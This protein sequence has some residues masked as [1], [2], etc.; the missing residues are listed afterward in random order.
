[1]EFT[2]VGLRDGSFVTR[3]KDCTAVN[4]PELSWGE[5]SWQA[6]LFEP[7]PFC[8]AALGLALMSLLLGRDSWAFKCVV[9]GSNGS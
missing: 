8:S 3:R 9:V 5:A 7:A 6:S 1:M 2:E 4:A